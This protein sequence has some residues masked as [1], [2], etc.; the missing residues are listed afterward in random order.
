M[1]TNV[2]LTVAVSVNVK[3]KCYC[4]NSKLFNHV[5]YIAMCSLKQLITWWTNFMHVPFDMMH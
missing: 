5:F 1:N 2:K 3:V 4:Y